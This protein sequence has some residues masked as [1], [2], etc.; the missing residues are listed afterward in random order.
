M[1][2]SN[3]RPAVVPS[4]SDDLLNAAHSPGTIAQLHDQHCKARREQSI[5]FKIVVAAALCFL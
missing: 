4:Q 2:D 5:C 3:L 1:V